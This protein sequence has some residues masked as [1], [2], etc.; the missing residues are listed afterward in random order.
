[1]QALL[2]PLKLYSLSVKPTVEKCTNFY[3]SHAYLRK[4]EKVDP[5]GTYEIA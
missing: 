5:A 1:M 2:I 4:F 3:N